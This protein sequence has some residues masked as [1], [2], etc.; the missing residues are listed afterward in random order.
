MV[1]ST[2][3]RIFPTET[4]YVQRVTYHVEFNTIIRAIN[5][6]RILHLVSTNTTALAV[7]IHVQHEGSTLTLTH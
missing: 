7:S 2:P 6:Q 5:N 3:Y 1:P 4:R